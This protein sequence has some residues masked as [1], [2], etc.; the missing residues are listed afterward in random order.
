MD[1]TGIVVVERLDDR[2]IELYQ[3]IGKIL[4]G[5]EKFLKKYEGRRKCL[6]ETIPQRLKEFWLRLRI[7]YHLADSEILHI[8]P[9][10]YQIFEIRRNLKAQQVV[11]RISED[12]IAEFEEI[13]KLVDESVDISC[14]IKS[15]MESFMKTA[16]V[17]KKLFWIEVQ[18]HYRL[19]GNLRL[20]DKT[21]AV[22]QEIETAES[23]CQCDDCQQKDECPPIVQF[24]IRNIGSIH[25]FR[26]EINCEIN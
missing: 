11:R 17:M 5:V 13:R 22:Y 12:L 16:E 6:V 21:F 25:P 4:M 20:D 10:T 18:N 15:F 8:D 14:A 2:F 19:S 9:D 23:Q 1:N 24:I 3:E 7:Q 26:K